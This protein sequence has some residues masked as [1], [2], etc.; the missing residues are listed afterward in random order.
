MGGAGRQFTGG[1]RHQ[2][3]Q[4]QTDFFY[5]ALFSLFI[6]HASTFNFTIWKIKRMIFCKESR[7]ENGRKNRH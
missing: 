2:N 3:R 6:S 4:K 5:Y 1:L 7:E